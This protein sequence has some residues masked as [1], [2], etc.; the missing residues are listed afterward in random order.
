MA[1]TVWSGIKIC[2]VPGCNHGENGGPYKGPTG[3]LSKHIALSRE[4]FHAAWKKDRKIPECP[5][6]GNPEWRIH[7]PRI[8]KRVQTELMGIASLPRT[9][10]NPDSASK[11]DV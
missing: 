4:A 7:F 2:P 10:E 8:N 1:K 6:P 3:D 11:L 5:L 9:T